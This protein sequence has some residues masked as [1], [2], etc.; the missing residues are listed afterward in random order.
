MKKILS[1]CGLA[2]AL[3]MSTSALPFS[4]AT[5]HAAT[6][7]KIVAVVNGEMITYQD[8]VNMAQM[9][10]MRNGLDVNNPAQAEAVDKMLRKALDYMVSDI[11]FMQ[12]AKRY[13]ISVTDA[14]IDAEINKMMQQNRMTVDRFEAQLRKDGLSMDVL[15][16]R[17]R[18]GMTRQRVL[19]TMVIR[20]VVVPREDIA[21][22]Y[23]E[24]KE[25]FM[26]GT[27]A[28]VRLLIYPPNVEAENFAR[29]IASGAK[30]FE[31]VARAVSI[32][33]NPENG[34]D[35]GS[36]SLSDLTPDMRAQINALELDGIS[37]LFPLNGMKAQVKLLGRSGGTGQSLE[38]VTAEIESILREPMLEARLKE[39]TEQLQKRAVV[40][41]RF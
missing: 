17:M 8:L 26:A 9:E 31:D 4:V 3:T 6:I 13:E 16:E 33:P 29:E 2:F 38:D 34:G 41:M 23:E 40:D 39:Y 5:L 11:L 19:G 30:S 20:K 1:A 28:Q 22:Y 25:R 24:H 27:E 18:K 32:G 36:V 35:V 7:N 15:R 37:P 12:E 21:K 14:E 10:L